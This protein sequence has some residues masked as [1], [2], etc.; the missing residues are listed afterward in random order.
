LAG[1]RKIVSVPK[2]KADGATKAK[3]KKERKKKVM[4]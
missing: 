1:G 4:L 3:S 2:K